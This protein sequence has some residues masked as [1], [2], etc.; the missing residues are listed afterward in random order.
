MEGGYERKRVVVAHSL[1]LV[2][3]AE[4]FYFVAGGVGVGV[5]GGGGG[6]G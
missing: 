2:A 6:G 4:G 3:T 5:R 1:T